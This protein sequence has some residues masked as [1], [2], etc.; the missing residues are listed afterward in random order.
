MDGND[1]N[2]SNG[3]Y[4]KWEVDVTDNPMVKLK[5][6]SIGTLCKYLKKKSCNK[7]TNDAIKNDHHGYF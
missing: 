1:T 4:D 6:S 2:N 7:T 3:T 5:S